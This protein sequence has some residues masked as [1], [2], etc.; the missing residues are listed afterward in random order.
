MGPTLCRLLGVMTE[1]AWDSGVR[2]VVGVVGVWGKL[3]GGDAAGA[4]LDK[5]MLDTRLS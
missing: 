5:V 4:V 2:G 1:W 3:S